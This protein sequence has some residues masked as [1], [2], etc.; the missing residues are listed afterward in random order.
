M[1]LEALT[2]MEK[3]F[4][5]LEIDMALNVYFKNLFDNVPCISVETDGW[6]TN[7]GNDGICV[8][9][10][11]I[12]KRLI[13]VGIPAQ[14]MLSNSEKKEY[15]TEVLK[16]VAIEKQMTH[17][18]TSCCTDNATNFL[19]A[20]DVFLKDKYFTSFTI[21]PRCAIHQVQLF[22]KDLIIDI[23]DILNKY[24][25]CIIG[26][27]QQ[28]GVASASV[29]NDSPHG[30]MEALNRLSAVLHIHKTTKLKSIFQQFVKTLP[31]AYCKTRWNVQF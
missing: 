7:S 4:R 24:H 25:S 18:I 8:M 9:I 6:L 14:Y 20:S 27:S 22:A 29:H 3:T 23:H 17:F 2:V 15:I 30:I 16:Y 19:G 5:E 12:N 11:F 26:S 21:H 1:N 28:N 13:K 31:L 10:N